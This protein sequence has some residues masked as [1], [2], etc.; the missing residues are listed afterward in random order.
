[1]TLREWRERFSG[2]IEHGAPQDLL[3]ASIYFDLRALAGNEQ[4]ARE[5]QGEVYEAA[6]RTPRFLKQMALNALIR[7]PPLNWLGAIDADDRGMVDLKLRGTA[8]FVDAARLYSLAHGN[9]VTSTRA[10]FETAGARMGL[11]PAEYQAWS[12]AFEFLQMLRLRVQLEG[13]GAQDE[14]NSIA[15]SSLN[16]I[17]RRILKE[18]LRVA[19][20]LQQRL[21]LDYE[22]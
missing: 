20:S 11:A 10:R 17:D 7:T 15:L 16:D 22:R 6:R 18:S 2:W 19:R 1:L 4:L 5:L 3:D 9:A 14:P 8:I 12:G 21:Q 13:G